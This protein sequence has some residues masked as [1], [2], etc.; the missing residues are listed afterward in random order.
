MTFGGR[1]APPYGEALCAPAPR[2]PPVRPA[3]FPGPADVGKRVD[4]RGGK[5]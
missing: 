3:A 4:G 1:A 2:R 5:G